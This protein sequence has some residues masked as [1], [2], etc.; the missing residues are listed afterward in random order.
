ML[1]PDMIDTVIR[2]IKNNKKAGSIVLGMS[3][4][5]KKQFKDPNIVKIINNNN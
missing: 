1:R 2:E 4:K 3:I 5:D